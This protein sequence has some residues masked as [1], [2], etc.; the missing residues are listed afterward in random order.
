MEDEMNKTCSTHEEEEE[1]GEGEQKETYQ[2]RV[3]N[4]EGDF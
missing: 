2:I 4:P 1:E 3:V